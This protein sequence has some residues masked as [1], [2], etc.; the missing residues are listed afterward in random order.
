M[1]SDENVNLNMMNVTVWKDILE[2]FCDRTHSQYGIVAIVRAI[3]IVVNKEI[4]KLFL[5]FCSTVINKE[6]GKCKN[7]ELQAKTG[8]KKKQL[9]T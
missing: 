5:Q 6:K 2:D 1:H 7:R 3:M 8:L 4:L 9:S